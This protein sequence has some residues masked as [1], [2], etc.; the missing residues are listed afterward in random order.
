MSAWTAGD[1]SHQE[2]ID[3]FLLLRL[4]PP[5]PTRQARV[6]ALGCTSGQRE[7]FRLPRIQVRAAVSGYHLFKGRVQSS[8]N[9]LHIFFLFYLN[10][11]HNLKL[12][13][14]A[15]PKKK[16]DAQRKQASAPAHRKCRG[17]SNG[18]PGKQLTTYPCFPPHFPH[19]SPRAP[20]LR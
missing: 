12:E 19:H 16:D 13:E 2:P 20:S 14:V 11:L 4:V 15:R 9:I 7:S 5:R 10:F 1:R 6:L 8:H 17:R 18:V 3:R